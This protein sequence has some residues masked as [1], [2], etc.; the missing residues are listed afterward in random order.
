MNKL[1]AIIVLSFLIISGGFACKKANL[2]KKFKNFENLKIYS[3]VISKKKIQFKQES[4]YGNTEK[5]ELIGRMGVISVDEKNRVYISDAQQFTVHVFEPDGNYINQIG[6]QGRGPGEFQSPP[7]P[8]VIS[9]FL[10]VFD[11]MQFRISIFLSESIEYSHAVNLNQRSMNDIDELNNFYLSRLYIRGDGNY[12]AAFS[13]RIIS[14]PEHPRYNL[15]KNLFIRYYLL[16]EKGKLLPDQIYKHNE[17]EHL[18]G[19]V[20]GEFHSV[21]DIFSGRTIVTVSDDGHI[22]SANPQEFLVEVR[23]PDGEE[24][25]SFYYPVQRKELTKKDI[26]ENYHY[27]LHPQTTEHVIG[28]FE[29]LLPFIDLNELPET[30]PVINNLLIDD[31]NR[32]WVSTIV[33]DFDVY[34]WWVLE[35][36]GELITKFEWPRKEPIEVV[37]NGYIYTRQTDEETGL[38]QIVRYRIELEEV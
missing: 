29:R 10:Y 12:M 11:P 14:D 15:N 36:T 13:P 37:K 2:S 35:E 4:L 7:I 17:F 21:A 3:T 6:R 23:D 8:T 1:I 27:L 20:E 31:E 34:E 33:E 26:L 38:Q 18:K 25:Y 22:F 24:L 30:W 19:N 16:D 9:R 28:R 5:G 32:L